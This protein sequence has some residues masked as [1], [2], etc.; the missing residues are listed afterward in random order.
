MDISFVIESFFKTFIHYT[1]QTVP[2]IFYGFEKKKRGKKNRILGGEWE[3]G[4]FKEAL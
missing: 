2:N 4:F 1:M 3:L